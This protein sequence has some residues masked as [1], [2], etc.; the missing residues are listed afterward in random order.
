MARVKFSSASKS[1]A[2]GKWSRFHA[3]QNDNYDWKSLPDGR[4][5]IEW[6]ERGKRRRGTAGLTTA[7]ALDAARRKKHELEGRALGIA[8]YVEAEEPKKTA[9][10]LAVKRYLEMV[11]ALKKPNT[12]R[13]YR[14]V[15]ER[16]SN[17]LH[18]PR[19]RNRSSRMI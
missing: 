15:L 18:L 3:D 10:H 17:S 5:L 6:Y 7:E 19:H 16:F 13:K 14:A 4:Y 8:E 11:Q 12:F 2:V 9:L 1:M